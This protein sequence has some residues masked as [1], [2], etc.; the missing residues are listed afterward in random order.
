LL[1][2]VQGDMS[3]M[4]A[5]QEAQGRHLDEVAGELVATS[6]DIAEVQL[7]EQRTDSSLKTFDGRIQSLELR[8]APLVDLDHFDFAKSYRGDEAA[9]RRRMKKYAKLFG[10]VEK[11]LDFGCGRGEFLEACGKLEIGAYGVDTDSDMIS[12][13]RMKKLD[14]KE[15]DG[16]AHL[17]RIPNRSLDGIFS[18]QLIEHLTPAQ[19][20]ELVRLASTKLKR[21]SKI[22]IETINPNTYS[23]MRWFHLDPS[24]IT[25]VPPDMLRFFLEQARFE[26]QDVIMS[27]PVPES[28]KLLLIKEDTDDPAVAELIRTLNENGRR[29]NEAIF[30]YQ[31]YAIVAER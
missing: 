2:D 18:A 12:H 28:E 20:V 14:V 22:V 26:V 7:L 29:L 21:G 13:C 17:R 19:I 10:P 27:S 9:L 6:E 1:R 31:D 25:P 8:L 4:R 30:G 16:L 23:A 3:E 5:V 15:E 11:I 24:H